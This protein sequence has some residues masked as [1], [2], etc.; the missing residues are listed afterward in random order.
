MFDAQGSS[1]RSWTSAET[2]FRAR[3]P[4]FQGAARHVRSGVDAKVSAGA[5]AEDRRAVL[6]GPGNG[7]HGRRGGLFQALQEEYAAHEAALLPPQHWPSRQS[8]R[9]TTAAALSAGP[10]GRVC[11][12]GSSRQFGG[13][14]QSSVKTRAA[15]FGPARRACR[16][17]AIKA[18]LGL[19]R[20]HQGPGLLEGGVPMQQRDPV[21]AS[22]PRSGSTRPSAAESILGPGVATS[23]RGRADSA[24]LSRSTQRCAAR[25]RSDHQGLCSSP[26][27][28]GLAISESGCIS[29]SAGGVVA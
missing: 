14:D 3:W 8:G 12:L 1:T 18:A 2:K 26:Q 16:L 22:P 28:V 4:G 20:S 19:A 11:T 9:E 27:E 6:L 5:A 21:P 23:A 17:R 13:Q 7:C 15:T 25:P 10:Q 29:K 24:R